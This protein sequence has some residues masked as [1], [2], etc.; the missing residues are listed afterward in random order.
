MAIVECHECGAQISSEAKLCPQCGAP[1]KQRKKPRVL[2]W[3]LIIVLLVVVGGYA[4]LEAA[5]SP[6]FC[7]GY[8]GRHTFVGV[9]D[10]SISA[11]REHLRVVDVISQK[12]TS[13]MSG[14]LERMTCEFEFRTNDTKTRKYTMSFE[15]AQ[16]SSGY[17]VRIREMQSK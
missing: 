7:E 3:A 11:Q 17:L 5:T 14:K 12:E 8:L 16:S 15:P 1:N 13:P 10:R 2:K 6:N 4:A 9:F